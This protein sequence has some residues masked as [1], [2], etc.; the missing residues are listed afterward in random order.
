MR[1]YSKSLPLLLSS[2]RIS[3]SLVKRSFATEAEEKAVLR[4]I[5]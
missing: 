1:S 4:N 2:S 3:P 5:F